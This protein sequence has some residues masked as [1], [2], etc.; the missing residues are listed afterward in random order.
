MTLCD[1]TKMVELE[2]RTAVQ[3]SFTSEN[4]HERW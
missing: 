4:R 3:R 2:H 1:Q